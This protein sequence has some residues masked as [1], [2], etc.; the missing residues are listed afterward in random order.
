MSTP[1][2]GRDLAL[3]ALGFTIWSAMFVALYGGHALG[4]AH[5]W[6]HLALGP[7]TLLRAILAGLF[8]VG[9]AATAALSVWTLRRAAHDASMLPVAAAGTS[10]AALVATALTGAPAMTLRLCQ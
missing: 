6:H 5:G 7:T 8:L 4:C 3:L 2:R 1:A 9:L 10:L